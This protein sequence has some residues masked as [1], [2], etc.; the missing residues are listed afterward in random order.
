[1]G[2]GAVGRLVADIEVGL[3]RHRDLIVDRPSRH[4]AL[5]GSL[6]LIR[7]APGPEPLP[8][9]VKNPGQYFRLMQGKSTNF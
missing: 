5:P 3:A 2:D 4:G 8:T 6:H 7:L 1:V 9:A